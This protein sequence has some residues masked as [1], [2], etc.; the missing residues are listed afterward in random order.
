MRLAIIGGT[1]F[2]QLP[3]YTHRQ[4]HQLSTP[5]GDGSGVIAEYDAGR[6]QVLFMPRH[7]GSH[8]IAPHKINYRANI[9]SLQQLSVDAVL[10]VNAVGGIAREAT[11]GSLSTPDQIIDY[12]W[13]REHTFCED[14]QPLQ[15]V[16]FTAPYDRHLR[17]YL[18]AAA[19]HSGIELTDGGVYG[20]TQGPRLESAAE[21]IRLERD[22]C[23]VVGMT[24]M[25]EAGLAREAGLPYASLCLVVNPAAGKSDQLITMQAIGQV[26]DSGMD[27]VRAL[28]QVLV[29]QLPLDWQPE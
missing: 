3:G 4:D 1:G 23:D 22:G 17:E 6:H 24:G 15:H 7:G 5:Y 25:P 20:C 19:E 28:L 18:L 9:W 11:A 13:G 14:P 16:D 8:S 26:L 12:S 29:S 10:A 21:I 2:Y 27:S